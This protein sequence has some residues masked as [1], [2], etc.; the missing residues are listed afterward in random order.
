MDERR[1]VR[2]A[3]LAVGLG[4]IVLSQLLAGA[5][6]APLFDGVV[7]EEPYRFVE[8]PPSGATDP[9]SASAVEVVVNGAM[10]LVAIATEETPPQAQMIA[11]ADAFAIAAGTT[12]VAVSIEPNP[13][14]D[15]RIV[16]NVYRFT[17]TDQAG[18]PLAIVRGAVVTIVLRAPQPD[19]A[20]MVAHLDGGQ[21]VTLTT[22]HGGLPDLYAANITQLGDFAMLAPAA[23]PS[24]PSAA[25]SAGPDGS[26]G[27][28]G[29]P[30]WVIA[31]FAIAAVA[32]GLT[33]GLLRGGEEG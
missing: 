6:T 4:L 1:R 7:V 9:F 26:G 30:T 20:A 10:P 33:M 8:P 13:P 28:T 16:G 18:A 29:I 3:I 19:P 2:A 32:V 31:L 22:Q 27:N 12:S 15:P 21:W 25:P 23:A 14:T 17:V 11:Q 24:A 5:A